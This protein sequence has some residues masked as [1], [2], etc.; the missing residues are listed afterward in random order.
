M[1]V[2]LWGSN[3]F[4]DA[5][6]IQ[7]AMLRVENYNL[8]EHVARKLAAADVTGSV[9]EA[10][11]R[12]LAEAPDYYIVLQMNEK[13]AFDFRYSFE[14]AQ[15][16]GLNVTFPQCTNYDGAE[17]TSCS[18]C[19]VSTYTDYNVT[20]ACSVSSASRRA[21]AASSNA[22]NQFGAVVIAPSALPNSRAPTRSPTQAPGSSTSANNDV[23][24]ILGLA[25]GIGGGVLLVLAAVVAFFLCSRPRSQ[26]TFSAVT[27]A[28]G[29]VDI[30]DAAAGEINIGAADVGEES[31]ESSKNHFTMEDTA[32]EVPGTEMP[33]A[34]EPGAYGESSASGMTYVIVPSTWREKLKAKD[35][36]AL[37]DNDAEDGEGLVADSA[38]DAYLGAE[39]SMPADSAV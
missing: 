19:E 26:S 33:A 14:E 4:P 21:L 13:Q 9:E 37:G 25:V 10:S 8:E 22:V 38:E 2:M 3:P 17:Y 6:S 11:S 31:A 36:S 20:F 16:L 28:E 15:A 24:L 34:E 5:D 29:A 23:A 12:E 35:G 18:G 1:A 27:N 30:E 7:S 32:P 39:D